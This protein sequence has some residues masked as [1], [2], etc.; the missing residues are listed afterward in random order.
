MDVQYACAGQGHI[1]SHAHITVL[2]QGGYLCRGDALG[3]VMGD[4][5]GRLEEQ[6]DVARSAALERGIVRDPGDVARRRPVQ[7]G[8]YRPPQLLDGLA[9]PF[10]MGTHTAPAPTRV[11]ERARAAEC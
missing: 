3:E 8:E 7:L 2:I 9:D 10:Q 5:L 11:R 4:K 6:V 1:Y